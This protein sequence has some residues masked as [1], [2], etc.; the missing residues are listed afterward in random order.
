VHLGQSYEYNSKTGALDAYDYFATKLPAGLHEKSKDATLE[1]T[2][3]FLEEVR[4]VPVLLSMLVLIFRND[5]ADNLPSNGYQLYT[6][7]IDG[8]LAHHFSGDQAAAK[9]VKR[10]LMLLAAA[11]Q[12]QQRRVF[13]EQHVQEVLGAIKPDGKALAEQWQK[14]KEAVAAGDVHKDLMD[15]PLIK[16][17]EAG[18]GVDTFQ[19]RHLSF[20]EALFS[21]SL[22]D[23]VGPPLWPD[24]STAARF[25]NDPYNK[26]VCRIGGAS[27]SEALTRTLDA[28]DFY[29]SLEGHGLDS[30]Q[31]L[32]RLGG[33][34][35][36]RSLDLNRTS[37]RDAHCTSIGAALLHGALASLTKLKLG[38]NLIADDGVV[39]LMPAV[40]A[41]A[42]GT[43]EE[44][45]LTDNNIGDRGMT[46]LAQVVQAPSMALYNLVQLRL[47]RNKFAAEGAKVFAAA[48]TNGALAGLSELYLTRGDTLSVNKNMII[49]RIDLEPL[50]AAVEKRAG[51]TIL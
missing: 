34:R 40:A 20:Q 1:R 30:L 51:L 10:L 38:H 48:L 5:Q 27:L 7:A 22:V 31:N 35:Q 42:L 36:L 13:T 15:L 46:A 43:L 2:L 39:A 16:T 12:R 49:G 47:E 37:I 29:H 9:Q 25:L 19:F 41:G 6:T 24:S 8:V 11:N 44:L 45:V 17:L 50:A 23:H 3:L 32:L 33:I 18:G 21:S 14:L 28:L 4:G 26:N